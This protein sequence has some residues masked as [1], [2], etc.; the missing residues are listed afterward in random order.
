[1]RRRL[2]VALILAA[3]GCAPLRES[4]CPCAPAKPAAERAQYLEWSFAAL[5]GWADARLEP[6]L[7]AFIAG[8]PRAAG[9]LIDA[10]ALASA[11]PP[12]DEAAARRF[13]EATFTAYAMV[14]A[15][16]ADS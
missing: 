7:N 3:A 4:P 8:C 1:M 16:G 6:S 5:P 12:G 11:V 15:D 10:C 2:V 14:S 13:F 9:A